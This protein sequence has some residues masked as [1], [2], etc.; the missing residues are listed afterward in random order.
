MQLQIEIDDTDL[1]EKL[2][3]YLEDKQIDV[4][5]FVVELLQQFFD[6]IH[7][8]SDKDDRLFEDDESKD[9]PLTDE[10]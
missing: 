5:D 4:S 2:L 3:H 6:N 8:D 1:Q 10:L 9:T 7:L